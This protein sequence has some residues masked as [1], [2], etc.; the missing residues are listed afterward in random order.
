MF[1]I[2]LKNTEHIK[3]SSLSVVDPIANSHDLVLR[4]FAAYILVNLR[5]FK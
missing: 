3:E 2:A 4:L 1:P 5:A